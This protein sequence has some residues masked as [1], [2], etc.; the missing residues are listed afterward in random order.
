LATNIAAANQTFF[1]I[2]FG[3]A[4]KFAYITSKVKGLLPSRERNLIRTLNCVSNT[5]VLSS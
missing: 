4:T 5:V 3:R 2:R 1:W